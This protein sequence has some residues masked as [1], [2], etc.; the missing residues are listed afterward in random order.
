MDCVYIAGFMGFL[1]TQSAANDMSQHW[2]I[3]THTHTHTKQS[4]DDKCDA[5]RAFWQGP[6]QATVITVWKFSAMF[7]SSLWGSCGWII[8]FNINLNSHI[9]TVDTHCL[10][11]SSMK[12]K[13]DQ[14]QSSVPTEVPAKQ[15]KQKTTRLNTTLCRIPNAL[16]TSSLWISREKATSCCLNFLLA[17]G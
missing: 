16:N 1:A 13:N 17:L 15:P 8:A 10:L 5:L 9:H 7:K 4:A 11:S 2:P 12:K 6:V 14:I 3:H